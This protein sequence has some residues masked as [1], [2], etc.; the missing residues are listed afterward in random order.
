MRN[1]IR[2]IAGVVFLLVCFGGYMY[3]K[4]EK[5]IF[6]GGELA[7]DYKFEFSTPFEELFIETKDSE[8]LNALHFKV[9]N[10]K[11]VLLYF[12]GNTG[13]LARWGE[14]ASY[15]TELNYN[16][17]VMDYRSYG[18][19][20]GVVN[21][22]A[23]LEDTQLFYN[24]LLNQFTEDQIIVYGRSIGTSFATYVA[25][26]NKPRKLILETP[27]YNLNDLTK[28]RFSLV[29]LYKLLKYKLPTNSFIVKV[30]CPIIII[31]GTNDRVVP[32]SSGEKLSK[33]VPEEQLTF[34]KIPN[35]SHNNLIDFDSYQKEIKK[36][37][38]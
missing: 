13:T 14:I 11:G 5:F 7:S 28:E 3:F 1:F 25:S 29:P 19:S 34:I 33:E 36:I 21:E 17:L 38:K 2:I 35:G 12:H 6:P 37:L 8:T 22:K 30:T 26:K 23:M 27:F 10:P 9:S 4:Q 18:K 16:V 24:Y 31:H 32:Y 15:F 20:T